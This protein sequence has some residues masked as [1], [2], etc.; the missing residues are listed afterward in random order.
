MPNE[1]RPE[2]VQRAEQALASAKKVGGNCVRVAIE[3]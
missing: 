1:G 3:D 2:L